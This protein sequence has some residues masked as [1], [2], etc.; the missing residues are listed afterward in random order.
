MKCSGGVVRFG[1]I[2]ALVLSTLWILAPASAVGQ[3]ATGSDALFDRLSRDLMCLCGCNSTIKSCPHTDCGYAIPA[4]KKIMGMVTDGKTYDEVVAAFVS[5]R[6]EV[7][8]ASPRK[9]GFNLVGYA[10]PFL[11]LVLAGAAVGSL[12]ARWA[13]Q[14]AIPHPAD[15]SE[16]GERPGPNHNALA[17]KLKRELE[18][19]E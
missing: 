10:M 4:R 1:V 5:E 7:A 8:L 3:P 14:G 15:G 11:A 9:E 17:E 13:K 12:V 16:P 2:G 6:G 19:F 18:E